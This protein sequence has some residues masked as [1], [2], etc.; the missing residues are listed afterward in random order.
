LQLIQRTDQQATQRLAQLKED[1]EKS[2]FQLQKTTKD[3]Q[4]AYDRQAYQI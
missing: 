4:I 3:T 2:I 1:I